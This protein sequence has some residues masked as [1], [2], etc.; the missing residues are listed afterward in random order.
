MGDYEKAKEKIEIESNNCVEQ[1]DDYG[2]YFY[3]GILNKTMGDDDVADKSL[4]KAVERCRA[5]DYENDM[6]KIEK[7]R[8][9]DQ[10]RDF[11]I[12]KFKN[13]VMAKMT[14]TLNDDNHCII[15]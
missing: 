13:L 12:L 7:M 11:F 14:M 1:T 6:K 5:K 9:N 15:I 3:H 2:V 8:A 10:K 4:L